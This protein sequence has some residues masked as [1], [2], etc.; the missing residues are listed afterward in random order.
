MC[1]TRRINSV[2]MKDTVSAKPLFSRLADRGD[3]AAFARKLNTSVQRIYNWKDRG[4]PKAALLEVSAA[5]GMT[6]E[7]YCALA[8]ERT[9]SNVQ[10]TGNIPRSDAEKLLVLVQTF[11][12]TD[13]E[14]R[15]ELL[16][17]AQAVAGDN[18]ISKSGSRGDSRRQ[19][20]RR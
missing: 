17:A 12:H 3:V 19:H 15:E 20:K 16:L 18:G 9:V 6:V 10:N 11:L 4:I 2:F 5:I 8:G 7:Q 14:G 13:T 1:R